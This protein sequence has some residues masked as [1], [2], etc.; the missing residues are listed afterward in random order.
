MAVIWRNAVMCFVEISLF[1]Y[2]IEERFIIK[3]IVDRSI[4]KKI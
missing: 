1:P 4:D 3:F 2:C